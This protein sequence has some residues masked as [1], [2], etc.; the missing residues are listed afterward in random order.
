MQ[1]SRGIA[2]RLVAIPFTVAQR[3]FGHTRLGTG[4]VARA[5]LG[6]DAGGNPQEGLIG[7]AES[8]TG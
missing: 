4:L 6:Q 7:L 1:P 5:E 8:A 2:R 3:P